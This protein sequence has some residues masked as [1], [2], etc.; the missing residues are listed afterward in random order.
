MAVLKNQTMSKILLLLMKK[1][2]AENDDMIKHNFVP[3]IKLN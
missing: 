3:S 2:E 1:E